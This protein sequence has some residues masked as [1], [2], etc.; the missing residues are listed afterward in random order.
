MLNPPF[1]P[2]RLIDVREDQG[3]DWCLYIPSE[4]TSATAPTSYMTLSHCWGKLKFLRLLNDNVGTLNSGLQ[5]SDVTKTFSDAMKDST[6]DWRS[7][8]GR[9]HSVYANSLLTIAATASADG[10]ESCF[11]DRDPS[12]LKLCSIT[13]EWTDYKN[14]TFYLHDT[15]LWDDGIMQAPLNLRACTGSAG[16][17]PQ[18]ILAEAP[19]YR[20]PSRSWA[21]VEGV[22]RLFDSGPADIILS[23]IT[24]LAEILEAQVSGRTKDTTSEL[25]DGCMVLKTQLVPAELWELGSDS[26]YM[27]IRE[28]R[29]SAAIFPDLRME[30]VNTFCIPLFVVNNPGHTTHM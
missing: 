17:L 9:M 24:P 11:R 6:D 7:E 1:V 2:T 30:P 28:K 15:Y 25:I 27:V 10:S 14:R 21:S 29:I 26:S 13:S 18:T 22:L 5:F 19:E 3:W 12:A 16:K 8:S 20:A 23:D 4:H